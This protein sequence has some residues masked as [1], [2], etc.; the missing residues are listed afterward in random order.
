MGGDAALIAAEPAGP[1]RR[2]FFWTAPARVYAGPGC[3]FLRG[4]T[5]EIFDTMLFD[6]VLCVA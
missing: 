4:N 5:L 6:M 3:C 1:R 2:V